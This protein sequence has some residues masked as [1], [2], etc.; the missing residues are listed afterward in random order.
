MLTYASAITIAETLA[1]E[2]ERSDLSAE[3]ADR[4]Q[5]RCRARPLRRLWRHRADVRGTDLPNLPWT[6]LLEDI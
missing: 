6:G 3:T 2:P 5:R 1:A 4:S